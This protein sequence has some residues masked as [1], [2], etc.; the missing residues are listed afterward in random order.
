MVYRGRG[1]TPSGSALR[2]VHSFSKHRGHLEM[3]IV[4]LGKEDDT[5]FVGPYKWMK[6]LAPA[7]IGRTVTAG[8]R[9]PPA[10]NFPRTRGR[11][12]RGE[13]PLY[14]GDA[15]AIMLYGVEVNER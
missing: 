11:G 8:R 2:A 13:A 7:Q 9:R 15:V 10:K 6:E 3:A 14:A 12:Y 4:A 5:V 1:T